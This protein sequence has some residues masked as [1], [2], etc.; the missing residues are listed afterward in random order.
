MKIKTGVVGLGHISRAHVE[1]LVEFDDVELVAFCD[2]HEERLKVS[3]EQY[4]VKN[5]YTQ[6]DSMLDNHPFDF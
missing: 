2:I 5:T 4:G 6:L 1:N 3:A